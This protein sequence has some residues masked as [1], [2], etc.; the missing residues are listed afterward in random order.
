MERGKH[1]LC[2]RLVKLVAEE[3]IARSCVKQEFTRNLNDASPTLTNDE[4]V[5]GRVGGWSGRYRS[6]W[7]GKLSKI[8]L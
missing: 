4:E 7:S 6:G 5:K 8:I 3:N 1:R 2:L